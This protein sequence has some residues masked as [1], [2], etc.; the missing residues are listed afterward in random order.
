MKVI[1]VRHP[2]TIWNEKG[3]FQGSGE[4]K[5][6]A[7]G[8]FKTR[9]FAAQTKRI[10]ISSIYYADNKRCKYLTRELVRYHPEAKI[11]KDNRLNERSFGILEGLSEKDYA[12][13]TN[14]DH[15]DYVG[16]Y[17][18]NPKGGESLEKVSLRVKSFL[19]DL[20]KSESGGTAFI[21]T[22][23]GVIRTS[24]YILGLMT[25]KEAMA[26]KI[27]NLEALVCKT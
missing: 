13:K 20:E 24:L 7:M 16:Q 8:K 18:W 11:L 4:S 1:L 26:L 3:L 12:S 22:S 19:K 10:R 5:I 27:K 9:E 25:L 21:I 15:K 17:K 23:G 6:S 14:F 2:Q